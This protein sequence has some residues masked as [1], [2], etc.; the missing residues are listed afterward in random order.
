MR[1]DGNSTI[2]VLDCGSGRRWVSRAWFLVVFECCKLLENF[3]VVL[4]HM[5]ILLFS[6]ELPVFA[7]SVEYCWSRNVL[8]GQ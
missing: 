7:C 4:V 3:K 2:L 5:R 1:G 6:I 8:Y